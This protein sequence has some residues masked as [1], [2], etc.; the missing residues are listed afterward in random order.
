MPTGYTAGVV[1]GSIKSFQEFAKLCIRNFGAAIHMRDEPM[2]KEYYPCIPSNYHRDEFEKK[3]KY[4]EEIFA[5]SDIELAKKRQSEI[6]KDIQYHS[7]RIKEVKEV[8]QR[9]QNLL[10]EA[11]EFIPPTK[12]HENFKQFMMHQ[13]RMTIKQDGDYSYHE[14]KLKELE[15][16][17]NHFN[18]KEYRNEI[19]NTTLKDMIYHLIE[20]KKEVNRCNEHNAW[21]NQLLEALKIT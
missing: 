15:D 2:D 3:Q 14:I 9:L 13:L 5:T 16:E 4:L 12:A 21:V 1:D 10:K 17:Y 6:K 11:E 19:I 18:V 20:Y 7:D 8:K